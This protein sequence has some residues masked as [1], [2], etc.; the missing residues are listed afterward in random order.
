MADNDKKYDW[1]ILKMI[2]C[3]EPVL[4]GPIESETEAQERLEEYQEDPSEIQNSH[5]II[6]VTHGAEIELS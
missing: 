4:I 2:G 1:Y 6:R 5:T 3:V